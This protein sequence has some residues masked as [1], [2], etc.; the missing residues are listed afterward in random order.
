MSEQRPDRSNRK[1]GGSG[2]GRPGAGGANGGGL[3]FGRGLFGWILFIALA[4]MLFMLLQ[5]NQTQYAHITLSDFSKCLKAD[6]VASVSIEADKLLGELRE[7]QPI[8]EKGEKVGK[9]QTDLPAN[10]S[11]DFRL[12]EWILTNAGTAK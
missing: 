7:P 1:N 9:F 3:R 10:T 2:G 4:V 12:T 11:A 8:G 6:Q 5:K